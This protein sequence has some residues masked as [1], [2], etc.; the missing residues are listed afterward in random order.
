M[1][2]ID[3]LEAEP[4]T[5]TAF[6]AAAPEDALAES[7]ATVAMVGLAEIR[8][9]PTIKL[10]TNTFINTVYTSTVYAFSG[11]TPKTPVMT[12]SVTRDRHG[13]RKCWKCRSTFQQKKLKKFSFTLFFNCLISNEK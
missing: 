9:N 2:T 7:T 1:R 10:V 8:E 11:K 3:F 12:G 4:L 13:W 5:F 6:T